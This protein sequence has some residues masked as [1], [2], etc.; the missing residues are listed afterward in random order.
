MRET[1]EQT[2]QLMKTFIIAEVGINHNGDIKIARQLIDLA[3]RCGCHAVK[4]QKRTTNIVYPE[5]VLN[6]PRESPWGTTTRQQKEGLEFGLPQYQEI[7][8]YCREIGIEWFASAWDI[9]SQMFLR[10]FNLKHNKVASAML[11]HLEFLDC[12]A[13]EKK[14]TFLSTGMCEWGQLDKAVAIF[15]KHGCPFTLMHTISVYPCPENELNLGLIPVLRER[16][17]VPVGYSGH[18]VGPIPSII[19][20]VM[21]AVAIERHIT[22]D[23]TMYG[24]DQAA[25]LEERG[26]D[27]MVKGILTYEISHGIGQK[28]CSQA[29][30]GVAKKLRYWE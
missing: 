17:K 15:R 24:S 20:A 13:G 7:D 25:S 16:Y 3:R 30:K 9:E 11:T 19:A 6:S 14:P 1:L 18:E 28:T 22:L 23:R 4:F 8:R 5:S 21:G 12:V 10:Q 26:L 27:I 2:Q 29:E